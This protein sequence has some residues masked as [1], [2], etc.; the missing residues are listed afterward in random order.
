M[1]YQLVDD[2]WFTHEILYFIGLLSRG[3][4]RKIQFK[5]QISKIN[6]GKKLLGKI[7]RSFSMFFFSNC[8]IVDVERKEISSGP[9]AAWNKLYTHNQKVSQNSRKS[10]IN[11]ALHRI[12][13]V[14]V[15]PPPPRTPKLH[16]NSLGKKS[17]MFFFHFSNFFFFLSSFLCSNVFL[18]SLSNVSV[19]I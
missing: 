9:V 13:N 19:A 14:S 10:N 16:R 1:N 11:Q 15:T 7:Y 12:S 8:C 4:S 18:R 17:L 3:M 2:T 5:K 6:S